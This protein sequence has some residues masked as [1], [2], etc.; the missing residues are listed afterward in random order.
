MRAVIVGSRYPCCNGAY[1]RPLVV[2]TPLHVPCITRWVRLMSR[3][4][5]LPIALIIIATLISVLAIFGI[6]ANRQLLNTDNWTETSTKL[7][8][9]DAIRE[10]ISVSLVDQLYA[11]VDV[12]QNIEDVLPKKAAPLAPPIAGQL[13]TLSVQGVDKILTRPKAQR[14]WAAANRRAHHQ[15]L[16][17]VEDKGTVV[18]TANGNVTLDLKE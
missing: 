7:L 14:L 15:F 12:E 6:W 11:N 4:R 9:N 1:T 18:S 3:R 13:K 16:Q 17:I 5:G 8:E 2:P 10:Q